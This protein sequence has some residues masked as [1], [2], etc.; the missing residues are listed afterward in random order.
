MTRRTR[1]EW[2]ALVK[3]WQT[4][5]KSMTA[6]CRENQIH[7]NTLI[8]WVQRD[9]PKKASKITRHDFTELKEDPVKEKILIE[10]R[11]CKIH[12]DARIALQILDKCLHFIERASC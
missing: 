12:A 2:G 10:W 3:E 8:Y 11:G 4:S 9:A 5:G 1:E 6:W 7:K